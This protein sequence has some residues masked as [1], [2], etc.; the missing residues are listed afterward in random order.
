MGKLNADAYFESFRT[1]EPALRSVIL[2]V[3]RTKTKTQL[4]TSQ[5]REALK[6]E[7]LEAINNELVKLGAEPEIKTV[8][9]TKVLLI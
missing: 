4:D 5:G 1:F 9:L 6:L 2:A 3:M 8:Q 7:I